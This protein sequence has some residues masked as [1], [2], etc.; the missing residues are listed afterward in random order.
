MT[1]HLSRIA[2]SV[3]DL[4]KAIIFDGE[5]AFLASYIYGPYREKYALLPS[6]SFFAPRIKAVVRIISD[7]SVR[8]VTRDGRN[9][10]IRD[11][12]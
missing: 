5:L 6:V 3:R 1:P 4:H 10:R 9:G 11:F 8:N 12:G 7:M 2:M